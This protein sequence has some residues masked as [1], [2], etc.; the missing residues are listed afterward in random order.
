MQKDAEHLI[1]EVRKN[2]RLRRQM[3]LLKKENS[4]LQEIINIIGNLVSKDKSLED[5]DV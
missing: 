3:R 5:K 1:N 2:K 4:R